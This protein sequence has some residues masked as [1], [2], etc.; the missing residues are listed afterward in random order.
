MASFITPARRP[1]AAPFLFCLVFCFM[2]CAAFCLAGARGAESVSLVLSFPTTIQGAA[3]GLTPGGDGFLYG[4]AHATGSVYRLRPDGSGFQ[5]LYTFSQPDGHGVNADGYYPA[6]ELVAPG[7]G[8]LYGLTSGGGAGGTGTV[9][10][11]STAG[12]FQPLYSFSAEDS[13]AQNPDGASPY[14]G[15]ATNGNG[16]LYGTANA[17]G[18]NGEGTV[19]RL[20]ADGSGFQTLHAFAF[21]STTDGSNVYAPLTWGGDGYFYGTTQS[22]GASFFGTVYRIKP[23]GTGFSVLHSFSSGEGGSFSAVTPG[24]DGRF[25]GVSFQGGANQAGLLWGLNPDGTGFAQVHVFSGQ[26]GQGISPD[27][28]GPYGAL[29]VGADGTLYGTTESGGAGGNGTVFKVSPD[30]TGFTVLAAFGASADDPS[31]PVGSLTR[32]G[33]TIYGTTS[34]GGP[35][36]FGTVFQISGVAAPQPPAAPLN[37]TAALTPG[38]TGVALAWQ[39]ADGTDTGVVV[40]RQAGAGAFAALAALPAGAASYTDSG[41]PASTAYAYRIRAVNGAGSS[42]PSNVAGAATPAPPAHTHILW[43]NADGTASLWTVGADGSYAH[44]EFGP[45][46]GWTARSVSDAPDGTT[47]LLWTNRSG[48]AAVWNLTGGAYG[49]EHDFGPYGGYAAASLGTGADGLTRLL[50]DNADGTASLWSLDTGA[51]GFSYRNYGPF[52]GWA[53]RSVATGGGATSLLWVNTSGQASGWKLAADGTYRNHEYGPYPGWAATALSVG[54]DGG[55]HLLWD[56]AGGQI[57]LWDV[58]FGTG[59]FTQRGYGPFGGWT[60]AA[61]ATGP[62][63]TTRLLWNHAPDGQMSLWGVTAGGYTHAEYGPFPGWS[64]VALSAGP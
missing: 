51:G 22:G 14:S 34:F 59:A 35:V 58:D 3:S 8:F 32:I 33:T 15:L 44:A 46:A 45:Y 42:A 23:D 60:A 25:Y 7:D 62:D 21:G 1:A 12:A 57:A 38:G 55:S 24:T 20:R 17:G 40:E 31:D 18:P 36:G 6:R 29:A 16:Y 2:L 10:R 26:N 11:I 48:Q 54:P 9:Y 43:D 64:A 50:W 27:G 30:G 39:L 37:L 19:F 4:T 41:L 5:I 52:P 61:L 63:G 28:K 13:H 56:N 47:H 53:A 49:S